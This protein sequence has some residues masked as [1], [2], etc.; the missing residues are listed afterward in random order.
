MQTSEMD[1]EEVDADEIPDIDEDQ[2][3]LD[4]TKKKHKKKGGKKHKKKSPK[5]N[6][7]WYTFVRRA[8]VN[9]VD[10]DDIE[11]QFGI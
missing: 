6:K 9:T 11:E 4:I 8:F 2:S 5:D 7:P 10:P 3:D 1:L